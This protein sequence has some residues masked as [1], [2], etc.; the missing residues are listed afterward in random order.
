MTTTRAEERMGDRPFVGGKERVFALAKV[1][2]A[3]NRMWRMA[4]QKFSP[5]ALNKI[6][7]DHCEAI[8]IANLSLF[9]AAPE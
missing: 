3:R 8:K 2:G 4:Q 7:V 6:I 9:V 1:P 5:V